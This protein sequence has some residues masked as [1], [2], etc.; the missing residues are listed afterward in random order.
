MYCDIHTHNLP[1]HPEDTA[2]LSLD[3]S[4]PSLP[5]YSGYNN[6]MYSAGIHPWH[7][8]NTVGLLFDRMREWAARPEI[9]AIGEVGLDKTAAPSVGHYR[10]QQTVFTAEAHLAEEVQKPLIIHCVKAWDDVLRIHQSVNPSMPW[11]IHGFR[12][13]E[14]LAGQLLK[15]GFYLSFGLYYHTASLKAAYEN[16][17]LLAETDDHPVSIRDIYHRIINDLNISAPELSGE[18][19]NIILSNHFLF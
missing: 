3:I 2:L 17:R 7:V 10:L 8:S 12:G 1:A 16:R 18:I 19:E 15:A 9:A 5:K 4:N 11:I 13:K 6:I 14:A